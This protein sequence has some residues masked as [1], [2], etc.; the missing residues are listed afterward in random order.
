M[1]TTASFFHDRMHNI[2]VALNKEKDI[3]FIRA[4]SDDKDD[5]DDNF[6]TPYAL[7]DFRPQV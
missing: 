4:S 3:G 2:F 1:N 7:Q 6:I 5:Q